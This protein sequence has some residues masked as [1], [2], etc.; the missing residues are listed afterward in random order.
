MKFNLVPA[1]RYGIMLSG[2]LDSAVLL[3][4]ILYENRN[5]NIQPFTIPKHDGAKLYI[6][7]IL[8]Y[9]E[10]QF[11]ITLP[12]PIL[13][14]NPNLYHA[15]QGPSAV[16]EIKNKYTIDHLFF[17]S[18]RNPP[19]TITGTNPVRIR[20]ADDS[21]LCPFFEL[22]KTDIVQFAID[23]N[24]Q[25]LFNI[26]HTCT[27]QQIGRCNVC[28]QCRERAWAFEKLNLTDTGIL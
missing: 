20:P 9:M 11:N 5:I 24:V 21:I 13:V 22:Y 1:S 28:W 6:D 14:G 12:K 19:V 15:E 4:L 3:F 8:S 26:T 2:G 27:E 18:N 17:G 25:E 10:Q 7:N 16:K 23:Y